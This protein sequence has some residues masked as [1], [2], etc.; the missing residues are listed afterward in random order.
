MKSVLYAPTVSSLMYAMVAT[1]PNIVHAKG[2]ILWNSKLQE[3]TTTSMAEAEYVVAYDAAKGAL[4]LGQLAHTFRQVD[5]DST[6]VVYNDS[7]GVISLSKNPIHHSA[8]NH[9]D[10]RYH[11]VRDCIISGK[12][13][14]EKIPT[15]VVDGMSKCISAYRFQ[16]LWHQMGITKNRLIKV[17]HPGWF[18]TINIDF[19]RLSY[20]SSDPG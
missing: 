11:F 12:I 6:L 16:S 4:W 1:R 2:A 17:G 3:C 18:Q 9:I 15:T 19:L 10:V 7:Q 13:G 5:S 8:S 20:I 14:L